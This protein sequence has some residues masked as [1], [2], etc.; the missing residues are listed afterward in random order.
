VKLRSEVHKLILS[1]WNDEVSQQWK[2]SIIVP[3]H[4]K[5]NK[6]D[7]NNYRGISL[8]LTAYKILFNIFLAKLT[9]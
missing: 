9:P 6:T 4:T 3:I 7:R 5:G 8:L 1:V 2:D